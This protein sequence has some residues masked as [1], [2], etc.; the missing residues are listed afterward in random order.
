MS[1]HLRKAEESDQRTI[2]RMVLS[3]LLNPRDLRWQNFLIAEDDEGHIVGIG[4]VRLHPTPQG[5]VKELASLVV[6]PSQRGE[7]V[8]RALVAALEAQAGLPL[9]LMCAPHNVAYYQRLGY[10]DLP[11]AEMPSGILPPRPIVWFIETVLRTPLH[12]MLK[13]ERDI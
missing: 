9:Y 7:G 6:A 13:S 11:K 10:R 1:V 3:E 2:V 5:I 8:G 4:Q 12:I